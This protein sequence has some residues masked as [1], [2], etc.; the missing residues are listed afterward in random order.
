MRIDGEIGPAQGVGPPAGPVAAFGYRQEL[1]R[2]LGVSDLLVYGLLYISPTAVFATFGILYNASAGKVPLVYVIGSAAILFTA[3]SYMALSR[4]F[5]LAGSAYAYA[6]LSFGESA[7]F[8]AG[9][10]VTLDYLLAPAL[11]YIAAA[12]AIDSVLPGVPLAVWA[13]AL[14]VLNT[15]VNL[16]GIE[17]VARANAVLLALQVLAVALFLFF[18]LAAVVEGRGGAHFSLAPIHAGRSIASGLVLGGV[19]IGMLNYL[20]FDAISTLSEEARGG[21]ASVAKATLLSL[22][23]A[24][25]LFISESYLACL[26]VLGRKAFPPGIP[27]YAAFYDI[28]ALVG[29]SWLKASLSITGVFIANVGAGLTAQ[30]AI[31][32]LFFSMARDGQL[33][34]A[35]SHVHPR[36]GIPDRATLL[37]AAITLGLIVFFANRLTLLLTIVSFG[38]LTAFLFVHASVVKHFLWDRR[39]GNWARH[40]L[41]PAIGFGVVAVV[42]WGMDTNAKIVGGCWMAVGLAALMLRHAGQVFGP[43]PPQ[44]VR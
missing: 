10:A 8:L 14:V 18:A 12:V 17:S 42:I 9:W 27:T 19:S 38:A 11:I 21:A 29:G 7:G 3:L 6:K 22:L 43:K 23:I 36:R 26:L 28:V 2:S 40:L 31:S 1:K 20:G 5:P 39:S 41:A 35:L 33:P 37:V 30:A 32:R 4:E 34:R 16:K 24:S 15:V 44:S 13:G 25:A